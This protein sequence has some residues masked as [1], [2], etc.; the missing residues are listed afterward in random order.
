MATGQ[1]SSVNDTPGVCDICVGKD[2]LTERV[3]PNQ[4]IRNW[5]LFAATCAGHKNCAETLIKEGADVNSSGELFSGRCRRKIRQK[6]GYTCD[7]VGR[8]PSLKEGTPLFYAVANNEIE[9]TKLLLTKGADVNL[10]R[11]NWTI[12]ELAV[13]EG[14]S[15]WLELLIEA[16]AGVN[17]V[18]NNWTIL[19]LAVKEGQSECLELLIEAGADVNMV[20]N[21]WTILQLAV[22]EGQSECL[23]LLIEAGA[24]VNMTNQQ[25]VPLLVCAVQSF[26]W[27]SLVVK[28]KRCIDI[29]IKAGADVNAPFMNCPGECSSEILAILLDAGADAKYFPLH[30]VL[31]LYRQ[32]EC[33]E[34]LIQKGADVNK[35]NNRGETP[36]YKAASLCDSTCMELFVK[37]GADVNTP[38]NHGV[39]PL[40]KVAE[41][42]GSCKIL[43]SKNI[44][45]FPLIALQC[46]KI[47]IHR[48]NLR[49][50]ELI[51][52]LL[53]SGARINCR[54]DMGRNALELACLHP[55]TENCKKYAFMFLIATG[56]ILDG[57]K[58]KDDGI[59]IYLQELKENLALKHL[60]RE[61]IRKHLIDLDPHEHLFGRI[62]QLGLPS[63]VTDYLLYDY[64]LDGN[65]L[66]WQI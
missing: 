35:Q 15:K 46:E 48:S 28:H 54:D 60:C 18:R 23:E 62:P 42:L 36:M 53:K 55:D 32:L 25:A 39:T 40:M 41:R 3:W 64:S 13:K 20:R 49:Y 14:Q 34:L 43:V 45:Q 12:V 11:N 5:E 9:I 19:Q 6:A 8:F 50:T 7:P 24:D 2:V 37:S 22:K 30:E 58:L 26:G 27:R 1:R 57:H 10:V 52:I 31:G 4:K 65:K 66:Y 16:G 59:P 44:D 21:N 17:L 33:V 51:S 61:A 38:D 47:C 29:L 56:E 63:L